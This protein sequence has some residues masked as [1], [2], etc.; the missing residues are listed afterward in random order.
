LLQYEQATGIALARAHVDFSGFQR[1]N[2]EIE[3][4]RL[5]PKYVERQFLEAAKRVGLRVEPRADGLWRVE[6][7]LADLRS[8]RLAAVRRL[9]KAETEYRK[10]TFHKAALDEDRHVDAVLLGPGHPLYAAVDE[11]LTEGFRPIVGG[12]AFFLDPQAADPYRLHFFEITIK[13]LDSRGAE[14]PVHAEVVGVREEAGKCDVVSADLL[15]DLSPYPNAPTEASTVDWQPAAD[16]LK[17]SYQLDLR[18]RCQQER[19]QFAAVVRDYLERS[20]TA[21]INRAQERC[22][23]LLAEAGDRPEYKLASDEARRH[24]EDLERSRQ[25]RLAGLDRLQ[26]ARTGPV[27][28]LG[29]AIVLTAEG[30]IAA[31]LDALGREPDT[32][33]RR[34]KE[35]RAEEIAI[36]SLTADGFPHEN[37]QRVGSQRIGFDLRAH[38]VMDPAT[39]ALEVRRVEVKGYTRDTDIQ[40]TTNEW[41]KAQQLGP[42]YWLYVVWDPLTDGAELV[43]IAN[44]AAHLDHA[45]KEIV[46]TK[47]FA[48]P[49]A[50]IRRAGEAAG[51]R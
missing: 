49:A 15:V 22:M 12:T 6:H 40:L 28:H 45:K 18:Q 13:G 4:R 21:R 43:R 10:L 46:L 50:A 47:L 8:E 29:T 24:L 26:I 31:Q 38:R 3:E 16:R 30:E 41:Y 34:Q 39:G 36:A 25:E 7:V 9:G 17:T 33:L 27:R 5:M 32:D 44:P 2:L 35:L 23:S 37:I 42:T 20:F 48:I 1:Q 19:K 14:V 11:K 51:P